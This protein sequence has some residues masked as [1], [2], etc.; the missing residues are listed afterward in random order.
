MI[1]YLKQLDSA[2]AMKTLFTLAFRKH[3][4]SDFGISNLS[5]AAHN[6]QQKDMQIR[7]MS[8]NLKF[9]NGD[10]GGVVIKYQIGEGED[11]PC[12][13]EDILVHL[14]GEGKSAQETRALCVVELLIPLKTH[15]LVGEFFL[16][17]MQELTSFI[18]GKEETHQMKGSLK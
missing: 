3:P 2:T 15:Q 16:Y 8:K 14:R 4:S 9:A 1:Q 5:D 12:G 7:L 10:R 11:S 6:E 18:S 17:L 13:D